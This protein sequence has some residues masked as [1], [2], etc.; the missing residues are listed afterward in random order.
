ME[1]NSTGTQ[2]LNKVILKQQLMSRMD[3]RREN[4]DLE[5]EYV[6][7]PSHHSRNSISIIGV[8]KLESNF[9]IFLSV[10]QAKNHEPDRYPYE[11]LEV[12]HLDYILCSQVSCHHSSSSLSVHNFVE[13]NMNSAN[14]PAKQH[15]EYPTQ[16]NAQLARTRRLFCP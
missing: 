2:W 14:S 6:Y 15:P 5:V 16:L 10:I 12:D 7:N 3:M 13:S 11:R 8:Q 1:R 9:S 4:Y